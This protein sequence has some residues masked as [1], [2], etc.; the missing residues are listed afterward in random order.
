MIYTLLAVFM[1]Y[2]AL[3]DDWTKPCG[4]QGRNNNLVYGQI[5]Y[6]FFINMLLNASWLA[7]FV[8]NDTWAFCVALAV[9]IGM[10]VTQTIIM[11]Q[12]VRTSVNWV[13]YIGLRLG[14]GIYN[15]WV[16]AATILNVSFVIKSTDSG[17]FLD[18]ETTWA[19]VI[20]YVAEV[21]YITVTVFERNTIYG[22][23]WCWV[24]FNVND[25]SDDEM[26]QDH[27]LYLLIAHAVFIVGYTTFLSVKTYK[28]NGNYR[29]CLYEI[30]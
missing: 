5:G 13:E 20:L 7:I 3:P 14:F 10:V 4:R 28:K 18:H 15:G 9:I 25:Y 26:I 24:L 11:R 17:F 19:V 16:S 2:Q 6:I 8:Q 29:G 12:S 22:A 23:I 30:I 1:I 27:T 21:L